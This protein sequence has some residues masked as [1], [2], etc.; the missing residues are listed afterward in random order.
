MKTSGIIEGNKLIAEFMRV[1]IVGPMYWIPKHEEI[2]RTSASSYY[3]NEHYYDDELKYHSSWDWLMPVVSKCY[4]S[5]NLGSG[6]RTAIEESLMGIIDIDQTWFD[7]VEF[8]KWYNK[9]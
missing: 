8:I 4:E 1:A 9:K 2:R 7:V 6:F 5:G 3:L